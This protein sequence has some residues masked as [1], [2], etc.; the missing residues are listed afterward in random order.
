MLSGTIRSIDRSICI[1][2]VYVT[3]LDSNYFAS[4]QP[5]P[6]CCCACCPLSLVLARTERR[7][8]AALVCSFG[9]GVQAV[10]FTEYN[11][12]YRGSDDGSSGE[13]PKH[14]FTDLQ[15]NYRSWVSRNV[16]GATPA[17][18]AAA[19]ASPRTEGSAAADGTRDNGSDKNK[20]RQER[21]HK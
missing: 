3:H 19:A 20:W 8:T 2:T 13:P 18:A 6:I 4:Y 12:P 17:A 14:V 16:F 21:E 5:D 15:R 10:L 7:R 1:S 11:L 9:V